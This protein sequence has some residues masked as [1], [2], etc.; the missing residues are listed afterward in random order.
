MV[1]HCFTGV[2]ILGKSGQ[3]SLDNVVGLGNEI[4]YDFGRDRTTAQLCS[5]LTT[6]QLWH[7]VTPQQRLKCKE[8][9][10]GTNMI[11]TYDVTPQQRLNPSAKR[12]MVELT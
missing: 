3:D 4:A 11:I 5:C 10:G 9:D 6:P 1:Y 2:G 8:M 7:D 12:W